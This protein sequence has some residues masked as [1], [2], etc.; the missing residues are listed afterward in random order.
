MAQKSGRKQKAPAYSADTLALRM[1][2]GIALA[3]LGTVIFMAVDLRMNGNVFTG[4]RDL[5]YGL[6]GS[7]A[8][9]LAILPVWAGVL[10]IYSTQRQAPVRPL[11][12]AVL[13]YT[14][15]CT[16][17]VLVT[18]YGNQTLLEYLNAVSGKNWGD[19]IRNGY[20]T[21]VSMKQSGGALG[22]LL[23]WPVWMAMGEILGAAI[24]LLLTIFCV[25]LAINLTPARI[26]DLI[27]GKGGFRQDQQEAERAR[28]NQEQIAWQQEQERQRQQMLWQQQQAYLMQQ[29]QMQQQQ[30]AQA[31][32]PQTGVPQGP[33]G[34]QPA[35]RPLGTQPAGSGRIPVSV[36]PGVAEWQEELTQQQTVN[37]NAQKPRKS[38][39]FGGGAENGNMV[40]P[41][42]RGEPDSPEHAG[43]P[44]PADAGKVPGSLC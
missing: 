22:V 3:A 26:R 23:G 29:Q 1:L 14:G 10:V 33:T 20:L 27:T 42:Q 17:L 39:L 40:R 31:Y 41:E 11:L 35:G 44:G 28:Q 21:S 4:L 30:Q 19:V 7:M 16:F 25:L 43:G 36:N 8:L 38:W 5:C 32:P 9:I 15:V 24:V 34:Q 13:A 12:Y 18:R 2:A 6:T 37:Q